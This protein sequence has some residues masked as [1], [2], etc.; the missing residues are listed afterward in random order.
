MSKLAPYMKA[1]I[2]ALVAGLASLQQALDDGSVSAQE[3]TAVAIA[4]L[5]AGAVVF[6][7]PNKDPEAEHQAESVQPP[8]A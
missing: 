7:V 3:W 4:F 2:G 1:V 6:A 5:T 8:A